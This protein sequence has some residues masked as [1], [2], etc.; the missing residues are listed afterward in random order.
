MSP[1]RC[2]GLVLECDAAVVKILCNVDVLFAC[3]IRGRW[4][5]NRAQ[6]M[7]LHFGFR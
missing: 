2:L 6:A 5:I 4:K 7:R 3:L 1:W